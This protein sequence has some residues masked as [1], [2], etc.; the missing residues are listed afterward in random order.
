MMCGGCLLVRWDKESACTKKGHT[1]ASLPC[2][3]CME[4]ERI[5]T[6]GY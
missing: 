3:I 5:K 2:K 4:L 6:N 1:V